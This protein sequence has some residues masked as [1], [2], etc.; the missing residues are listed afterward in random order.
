MARQ[1]T[2]KTLT[3]KQRGIKEGY[4]SGLEESV[5]DYLHSLSV[6]YQYEGMTIPYTQPTK[7]R[8][9]TPDFTFPQ[10][11][12]IIETKGRFVTA[13]RQ[14]HLLLKD[15]YPKL[16]FRF[17]FTNPNQRISKLSKTTYAMWCEKY[18][19]MYAKGLIP[20]SWLDEIK[21]QQRRTKNAKG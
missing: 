12:I 15:Q 5:S 19:F 10:S 18:G 7:Q 4:R 8:K 13:D 14:K 20:K 3:S 9:Y 17:V 11:N 6:A 2:K 16:D 21:E 1:R